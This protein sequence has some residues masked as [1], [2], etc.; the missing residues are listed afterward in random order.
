M[1]V[2]KLHKV[3]MIVSIPEEDWEAFRKSIKETGD[4]QFEYRGSTIFA[5]MF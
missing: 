4:V 2:V 5:E 1:V 3:A